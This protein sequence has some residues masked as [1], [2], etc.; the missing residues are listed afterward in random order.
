MYLPLPACVCLPLPAFTSLVRGKQHLALRQVRQIWPRRASSS[1]S[2]P[3]APDP[4]APNQLR[5]PHQLRASSRQP[6]QIWT[7]RASTH[8]SASSDPDVLAW[9][10]RGR[11]WCG[12]LAWESSLMGWQTY[13]GP[14]LWFL[15]V[16]TSV[17]LLLP[18]FTCP[19]LSPHV[20]TC[21]DVSLPVCT[22]LYVA[23]PAAR[24]FLCSPVTC[25]YLSL[26]VFSI[27]CLSLPVFTWHYTTL[28]LSFTSVFV[29]LLCCSPIV[30][31]LYYL[32][33][34]GSRFV[35]QCMSVC[36]FSVHQS[37]I[38]LVLVCCQLSSSLL[39][40]LC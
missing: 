23:L 8:L 21:L 33:G 22:T 35:L 34:I 24:T 4:R 11:R 28:P 40:A 5:R 6:R 2:K 29:P 9:A 30:T 12:D 15:H 20:F 25:V 32:C 39:C 38:S 17:Y 18:V 36:R 27:L 31:C 3:V 37:A 10:R 13:R 1:S 14:E 16:F 7:R 19:H 26:P